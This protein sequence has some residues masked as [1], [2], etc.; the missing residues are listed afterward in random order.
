MKKKIARLGFG[1]KFEIPVPI[2]L[3]T[4]KKNTAPFSKKMT[5]ILVTTACLAFLAWFILIS[6]QAANWGWAPAKIN[7]VAFT[8]SSAPV[9]LPPSP[10]GTQ[11]A[12]IPLPTTGNGVITIQAIIHGVAQNGT[13]SSTS[14]L[15]GGSY[16]NGIYNLAQISKAV[17]GSDLSASLNVVNGPSSQPTLELINLTGVEASWSLF[18]TFTFSAE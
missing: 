1:K 11:E 12:A 4:H 7:P 14:L 5:F 15:L 3:K 17:Q 9:A 2:L 8:T 18:Y 13:T 6:W 10:S 16:N